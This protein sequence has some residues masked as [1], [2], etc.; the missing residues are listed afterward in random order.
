M[1]VAMPARI[2]E[3]NVG[4]NTTYARE[5]RRGLTERHVEVPLMPMGANPITTLLKETYY[6]LK[7]RSDDLVLHYVADTGPLL[8]SGSKVV[9]TVH[10]VASRWI[11]TARTPSQE[12]IWRTRVSKAIKNS[13]KVIT[14]SHSS[15]RDIAS[16]FDVELEDINVIPHGIRHSLF[17]HKKSVSEKVGDAIPNEFLLY[18]GNIEPRKNLVELIKA[19]ETNLDLPP[20]VIAGKPA[21]NYESTMKAIHES[22]RTTYLGFISNDDRAALMARCTAFIFPSLYEGFGFPV[23]EAMA[24]GARVITTDRGSLKEVAGPA[25]RLDDTDRTSISQGILRALSDE[26]W[27]KSTIGA[28]EK[29][30]HQFTWESSI[31]AHLNVYKELS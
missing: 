30:V 12:L 8:S 13:Q 2:L 7:H 20:L 18:V 5:L 1:K 26:T 11:S 27:M 31:E 3:K 21:W 22:S 19:I 10:G 6:G 14:V 28:G 23:L 15:A 29:W 9:V 17:Q 24:S 4:G 25:W 16:I